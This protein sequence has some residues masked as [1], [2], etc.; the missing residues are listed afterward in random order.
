[1]KKIYARIDGIH[2]DHCIETITKEL[3]KNKKIKEVS[4]HKNI[5]SISYQGNL[6][7]KEIIESILK[8]DYITKEEYI[9]DNIK[10]LNSEIT[11]KEFFIFL[12]GILFITYLL[13]K[14]FGFNIFNMIPTIDSKITYGMLMVTG[15]LTSIHCISMCGAINLLASL[16]TKQKKL[17]KPIL[18]NL[19]RILSYTILGGLVGLLGSIL[20]VNDTVTAL[21]TLFASAVMILMSL[22]MLGIIDFHLPKIKFKKNTS[23]AF[24]IGL[25]NGFMPCGPLQ[26]MQLYAL[27]TGSF[28]KGAFS[29]FLFGIGTVPLMLSLGFFV[30]IIKGKKK[31][32]LNKIASILILILSLVMLNRGLLSLGIDITKGFQKNSYL[33]AQRYDDYQEVE[34]DL[35]YDHYA[36]IILQKD[37]KAR[38]IIHVDSKHLTGCNN[39]IIMKDFNIQKKLEVGEN[40]IEFT[41]T[42]EGTFTYHCWMEMITNHIKVVDSLR[43][44]SNE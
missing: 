32:L 20:S 44:K 38:I 33:S 27:S 39:E 1:M 28:L 23:N 2:C 12:F 24:W 7:K 43:R 10:D 22:H 4:I 9:K 11:L 35:D 36:D 15:M 19:G 29:M 34:F 21:I 6:S 25:L 26:A 18:Y 13:N 17:K 42:K 31:I 37:I 3:L 14:I 41:P 30:N 16:D 40:I 8:I 5:A